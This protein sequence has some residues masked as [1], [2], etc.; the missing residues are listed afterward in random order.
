MLLLLVA[1]QRFLSFCRI[2]NKNYGFLKKLC[3]TEDAHVS[4]FAR[5][6][7]SAGL[8]FLRGVAHPVSRALLTSTL[9]LCTQTNFSR[10]RFWHQNAS[11]FLEIAGAAHSYTR[12]ARLCVPHGV[13]VC[14]VACVSLCA[15]VGIFA[16]V[17]LPTCLKLRRGMARHMSRALVTSAGVCCAQ[18]NFSR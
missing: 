17:M 6:M 3:S 12:G 1:L 7:L 14:I 4:I 16:R 11:A 18:T 9:H 5:V 2:F 10:R 8:Q 13:C 15:R